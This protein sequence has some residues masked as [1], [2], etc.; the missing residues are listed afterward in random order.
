MTVC[1]GLQMVR[2]VELPHLPHSPRMSGNAGNTHEPTSFA[3]TLKYGV[4][5]WDRWEHTRANNLYINIEMHMPA[6]FASTLKFGVAGVGTL[7]TH[8]R[9]QPLHQH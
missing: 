8:A 4:G 6:T 3:S 1:G 7:G 5:G 9:Q 2:R